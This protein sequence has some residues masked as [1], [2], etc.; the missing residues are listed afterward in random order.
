M[1]CDH[2]LVSDTKV[3]KKKTLTQIAW[4]FSRGSL[5]FPP[6][7]QN[8]GKKQQTEVKTS[9]GWT[10]GCVVVWSRT[11]QKGRRDS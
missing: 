9:V 5:I 6:N 3:W 2:F 7:Y 8:D 1:E 10:E 4:V 11:E